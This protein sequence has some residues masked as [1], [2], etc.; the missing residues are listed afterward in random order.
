LIL[1]SGRVVPNWIL[2]L[3]FELFNNDTT[4]ADLITDIETIMRD[5]L[6]EADHSKLSTVDAL[7]VLKKFN[8]I[9]PDYEDM[10]DEFFEKHGLGDDEYSGDDDDD[11]NDGNDEPGG[12][13]NNV[14]CEEPKTHSG[15]VGVKEE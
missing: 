3:A 10:L 11:E 12:P 13:E 5:E 4:M 7:G 6:N 2:Q 9:W 1:E 8:E 15:L 14:P